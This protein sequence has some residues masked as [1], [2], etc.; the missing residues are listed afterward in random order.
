M[1]RCEHQITSDPI[2]DLIL[3]VVADNAF[4]ESNYYPDSGKWAARSPS[5]VLRSEPLDYYDGEE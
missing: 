2:E 1:H 5:R 4:V 3:H